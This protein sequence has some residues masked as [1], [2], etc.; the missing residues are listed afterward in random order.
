MDSAEFLFDDCSGPVTAPPGS[1][2]QSKLDLFD[3][4][5]R[6]EERIDL[7]EDGKLRE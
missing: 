4:S 6:V 2:D 3:A 7:L 5:S 1:L